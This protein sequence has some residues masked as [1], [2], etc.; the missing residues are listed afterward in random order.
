[1]NQRLI[2]AEIKGAVNGFVVE[3]WTNDGDDQVER[4]LVFPSLD[5]ALDVVRAGFTDGVEVEPE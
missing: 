2:S 3:M 4:L 5:E 1:M